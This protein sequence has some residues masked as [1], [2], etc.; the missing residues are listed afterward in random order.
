MTTLVS[1]LPETR[2][3]ATRDS[4]SEWVQSTEIDIAGHCA[5]Y[6]SWRS[7]LFHSDSHVTPCWRVPIRTKQL[8]KITALLLSVLVLLL[9]RKVVF[10]T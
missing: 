2:D 6:L 5:I 7:R 9:S 8:S 3:V 4:G 10:F 1:L